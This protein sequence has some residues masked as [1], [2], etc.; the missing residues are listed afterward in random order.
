MAEKTSKALKEK[1]KGYNN[2]INA[3]EYEAALDQYYTNVRNE[4]A[5]AELKD[6]SALKQWEE[7]EKIRQLKIAICYRSI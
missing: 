2:A 3:A 7:N 5:I 6:K 4:E 1:I